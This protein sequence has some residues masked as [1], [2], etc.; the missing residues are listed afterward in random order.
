MDDERIRRKTQQQKKMFIKCLLEAKPFNHPN[1]PSPKHISSFLLGGLFARKIDET[2]KKAK[3]DGIAW[4]IWME[5]PN[6]W[7]LALHR[8]ESNF[9]I[10]TSHGENFTRSVVQSLKS[11]KAKNSISASRAKEQQEKNDLNIKFELDEVESKSNLK[12]F[13]SRNFRFLISVCYGMFLCHLIR[14]KV[15]EFHKSFFISLI[16]RVDKKIVSVSCESEIKWRERSLIKLSL[17]WN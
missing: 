3:S 9:P 17:F 6:R 12:I 14:Q 15:W 8:Q 4:R 16:K 11:A 2:K 13:P 5:K 7:A 1:F 10:T